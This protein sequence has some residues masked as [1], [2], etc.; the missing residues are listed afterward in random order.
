[1]V[2]RVCLISRVVADLANS[3]PDAQAI[4][5]QEITEELCSL[6]G[7]VERFAHQTEKRLSLSTLTRLAKK[8]R[9]RW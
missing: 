1:M 7:V 8:A 3:P 2:S 5:Q 4:A 9:L 6:K